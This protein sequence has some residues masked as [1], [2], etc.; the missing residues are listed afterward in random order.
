METNIE[1]QVSETF[2]TIRTNIGFLGMDR[3]MKVFLVTSSVKGEGKTTVSCRIAQAYVSMKKKVLLID[4]DLRNP[5]VSRE[6]GIY[7]HKGLVD[8]IM[9]ERGDKECAE[10]TDFMVNANEY[11]DVI[12]TGQRPPNP[13][14]LLSSRRIELILKHLRQYY[15][16]ILLDTPPVLI[17]SDALSLQRLADG[18]LLV[19]KYGYTTTE[20]LIESKR[21]MEVVGVKPSACILNGVPGMKKKNPYYGYFE[22]TGENTKKK[23][24]RKKEPTAGFAADRKSKVQKPVGR[25]AGD[26]FRQVR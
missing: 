21:L 2:N 25:K 7:K 11:L 15:D 8:L 12:T 14:E 5:S 24:G 4:C 23:T 20:M 3:E 26:Y 10:L 9:A 19:I 16:I 1:Q 18:I 13:L 17:V 22:Y 6:L